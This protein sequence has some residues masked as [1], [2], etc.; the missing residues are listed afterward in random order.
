MVQKKHTIGDGIYEIQSPQ[1]QARAR[2]RFQGGNGH[3]VILV[4]KQSNGSKNH[5]TGQNDV[6][7]SKGRLPS[8][9]ALKI[10]D[11]LSHQFCGKIYTC[12]ELY[13]EYKYAQRP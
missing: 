7:D 1:K 2:G 13:P 12:I 9:I 3:P 4:S 10:G 6:R 8:I 11:L 5:T